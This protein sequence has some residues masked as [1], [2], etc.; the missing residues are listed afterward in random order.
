MD[1]NQQNYGQREKQPNKHDWGAFLGGLTIGIFSTLLLVCAVLLVIRFWTP[2]NERSKAD[3]GDV[4]DQTVSRNAN[5]ILTAETADKINQLVSDI[6]KNFYLRDV[7]DEELT[8]GI[9]KGIME[10]LDDPYSVYYTPEEFE[11]LLNSFEGVYYGIGAYISLDNETSL[12]KIS[13]VIKG[14]PAEETG[15]R[16]NDLIYKVDGTETY[17]MQLE[18]AVKMIKGDENTQV[19]LT[20]IREGKQMDVSVTRRKVETPTVNSEMLEN[21]MGY[22]QIVSFDDVTLNQFLNAKSELE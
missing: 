12:P 17:G 14:T 7:T 1:L 8:V 19:L 2:K 13:G 15:L 9:Y 22:L 6:H 18:D 20:L 21:G 10:A 3:N 4:S 16:N 11:E 5:G